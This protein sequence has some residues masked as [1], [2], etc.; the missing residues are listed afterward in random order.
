M[1]LFCLC[2]RV[3]ANHRPSTSGSHERYKNA[4]RLAWETT[5]DCIVQMKKWM[6]ENSIATVEE[7]EDIEKA[8]KKRR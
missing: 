1:S 8:S 4:E 7:I 2:T 3:N 5:F 6:I